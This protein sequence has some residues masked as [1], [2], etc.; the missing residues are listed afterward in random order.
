[1]EVY[2]ATLTLVFL[3]WTLGQEQLQQQT[4]TL[5]TAR[6]EAHHVTECDDIQK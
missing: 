6:E 4:E 5:A 1:M 3:P 2:L